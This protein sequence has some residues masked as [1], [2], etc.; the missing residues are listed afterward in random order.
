MSW[1]AALPADTSKIRLSAGYL[2]DN[3]VAIQDV[4]S[5]SSLNGNL[6]YLPYF[7]TPNEAAIWVYLDIA[8]SGWQIVGTPPGDCLLGFKGGPVYTTGKTVAGTWIGP[9]HALTLAEVPAT[10]GIPVGF[11]PLNAFQGVPAN[12]APHSHDYT[13]AP[14]TRPMSAVGIL[15]AKV[16]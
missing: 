14:Q 5:A 12:G 2:R 9:P 16:A 3:E 7:N 11:G 10:I 6:P 4:I 1:N 8:P 15:I 13:T